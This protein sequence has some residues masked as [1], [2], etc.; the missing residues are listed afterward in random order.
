MTIFLASCC[1]PSLKGV[2]VNDSPSLLLGECLGKN[3]AFLSKINKVV[4]DSHMKCV[5]FHI[6]FCELQHVRFHLT[7][8]K[9]WNQKFIILQIIRNA[10]KGGYGI[11]SPKPDQ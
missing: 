9:R 1:V 7:I 5:S 11:G 8:H 4:K 10:T 2:H 6:V 3:Q